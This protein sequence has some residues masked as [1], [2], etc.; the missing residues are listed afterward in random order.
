MRMMDDRLSSFLCCCWSICN[1]FGPPFLL[2][3]LNYGFFEDTHSC[4]CRS[5]QKRVGA[6]HLNNT[7][8]RSRVSSWSVDP[9]EIEN[10]KQEI[11]KQKVIQPLG[12]CSSHGNGSHSTGCD[13]ITFHLWPERP[14]THRRLS[15]SEV[16]LRVVLPDSKRSI[17]QTT[18]L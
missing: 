7:T 10:K 9:I 4:C 18:N 11:R 1:C 17:Q 2:L 13:L 15:G 3:G 16:C 5:T 14:F 12:F 8:C 6:T